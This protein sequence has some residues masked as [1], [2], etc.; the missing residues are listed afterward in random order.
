MDRTRVLVVDDNPDMRASLKQLL[1]LL[2]YEVETAR[3]GAS[4]LKAHCERSAAVVITDILMAGIEGIET[5]ARF[6]ADW[7]HVRVIAMSS[8]GYLQAAM[9]VGADAIMQKPFTVR[10]LLGVL[11]PSERAG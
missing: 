5:I 2:G 7:P 1:E 10:T 4:A 11:M 9:H 6:K 3:D 8:G